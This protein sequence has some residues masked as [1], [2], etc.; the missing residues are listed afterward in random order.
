MLSVF[1]TKD[2][3]LSSKDYAPTASVNPHCFNGNVVSP[4]K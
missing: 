1:D 2:S 4:V 3:K